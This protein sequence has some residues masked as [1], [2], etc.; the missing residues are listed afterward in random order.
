MPLSN[1]AIS[2]DEPA[3]G[4]QIV[5]QRLHHVSH[6]SKQI[7][8]LER[9]KLDKHIYTLVPMIVIL[10]PTLLEIAHPQKKKCKKADHKAPH[11]G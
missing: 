6:P 11:L 7:A 10:H 8:A 3:S 5:A 9:G 1:A 4:T 2:S